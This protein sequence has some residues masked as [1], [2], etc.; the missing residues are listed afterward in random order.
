MPLDPLAA[1]TYNAATW[2]G[3][4]KER[5]TSINSFAGIFSMKRISRLV[6]PRMLAAALLLLGTGMLVRCGLAY[7]FGAKMEVMVAGY[8]ENA[9]A[10]PGILSLPVVEFCELENGRRM[11][12]PLSWGSTPWRSYQPG[13]WVMIVYNEMWP[14]GVFLVGF[15]DTWLLPGC[16]FAAG[17]ILALL[18][19][20]NRRLLTETAREPTMIIATGHIYNVDPPAMAHARRA[21]RKNLAGVCAD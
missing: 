19:A 4:L 2:G 14:G 11:Q 10:K 7:R 15:F 21:R 6:L 18:A 5:P 13:D 20:I 8:G 9:K 12:L 17:I 16:L 3:T 1:K